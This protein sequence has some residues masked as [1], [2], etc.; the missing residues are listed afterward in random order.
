MDGITIYLVDNYL[1]IIYIKSFSEMPIMQL[2]LFKKTR[3][4]PV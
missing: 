4:F 3:L 2:W 1:Q